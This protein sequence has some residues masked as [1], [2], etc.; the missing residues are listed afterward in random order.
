MHIVTGSDDNY[1]PGVLVLIASAAWHNPGARFTVLDMGISPANRRRISALADRLNLEINRIEVDEQRLSS[2]NVKRAHLNRSAYLRLLIPDL[3]SN[4][5]RVLYMDCDMV[6]TAPLDYLDAVRLDTEPVAAVACP[7][8]DPRELAATGCTLGQYINSGLLVMN[9]PVWRREHIADRCEALLADPEKPLMSED[10]SAIN[11]VCRGRIRLLPSKYNVYANEPTYKRVE[12]VPV[13]A[14]VLHYVVNVKPW[15]WC[16]SF[17]EI[18]Q[19]HADR[20]R[21]LMPPPRPRKLSQRLTRLEMHRRMAFG[22]AMGRKKH[23]QR[24]KVRAA[25][26]DGLVA[27]YLAAQRERLRQTGAHS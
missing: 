3:L 16:V 22:L 19:F 2:L 20:I 1:V 12:D 15:L 24:L 5:D 4:D 8:P 13:E 25:I 11:I 26:R 6:V 14:A 9:L 7:S 23:W 10:Q 21:D 27:S 17:G 18:W